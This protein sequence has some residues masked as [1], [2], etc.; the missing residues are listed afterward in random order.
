[1]CCISAAGGEYWRLHAAV[2]RQVAGFCAVQG[3]HQRHPS[4][5]DPHS[6]PAGP[7]SDFFFMFHI[8]IYVCTSDVGV[9]PESQSLQCKAIPFHW[10]GW[11]LMM[12]KVPPKLQGRTPA[13]AVAHLLPSVKAAAIHRC[14][15]WTHYGVS[16]I[17]DASY[18][19]FE[20]P[21]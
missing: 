20:S 7:D 10:A 4:A 2:E 1:M 11:L 13:A 5:V 21:S 19:F 15:K 9:I 18:I 12:S 8:I 14:Y 17:F 16:S 3:P 6:R